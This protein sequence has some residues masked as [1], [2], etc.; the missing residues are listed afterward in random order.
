MQDFQK[1]RLAM[2]EKQLRRRDVYDSRVLGAMAKVFRQ[3]FVPADYQAAAYEDR[4]L[5][6]GEGQTISQP[7]M[8][9][10]MTQSLDLKG[11]ERVLEIGTGSGYQTA[12][13]AELSQVVFTVERIPTLIQKAQMTLEALGYRNIF[14]LTGDGTKG[15][16]EEAP[17]E[18]IIVTAGAPEIPKTLLSQLAEGGRLVIPVGPRYTQT[19]YKVTRQGSRFQE[20]DITGCVFVPLLGDYG[21]KEE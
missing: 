6:I 14:F 19:L 3:S 1:E 4:P 20:D 8:V 16:Q 7:Y 10:V 2:V 15:W 5:P 9:A 11:K 12:I 17:F 18:G 21:W 13:L